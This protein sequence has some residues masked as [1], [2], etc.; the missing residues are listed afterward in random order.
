MSKTKKDTGVNTG[1][2]TT[3]APQQEELNQDKNIHSDDKTGYKKDVKED[4]KDENIPV[5]PVMD[6][7]GNE[8]GGEG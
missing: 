2:S 8:I 1:N 7:D 3:V 6:D 4:F 5:E